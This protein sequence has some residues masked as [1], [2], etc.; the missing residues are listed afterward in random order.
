MLDT[1][2]VGD[3]SIGQMGQPG[4]RL[5]H[6]DVGDFNNDGDMEIVAVGGDIDSGKMAIWDPVVRTGEP[7]LPTVN[8]I[9]W[10][11][12]AQRLIPGRPA[13]VKAGNFDPNV[14]GD[15]ILYGFK[16]QR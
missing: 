11:L 4:R 1:H 12:A 8:G 7:G 14:P 5:A 10:K 16:M 6:V 15:E 13:I 3:K 9:P 2:Q